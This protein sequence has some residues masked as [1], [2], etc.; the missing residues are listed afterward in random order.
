MAQAFSQR[1]LLERGGLPWS[2]APPLFDPRIRCDAAF[3]YPL[4]GMSSRQW[5][6]V[7]QLPEETR[8]RRRR[9][10]PPRAAARVRLQELLEARAQ[11][12]AKLV[13]EAMRVSSEGVPQNPAWPTAIVVDRRRAS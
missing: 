6:W 5:R 2:A 3:S 1:L 8:E 12:P 11:T 4:W 10:E 9:W 7:E 13:Y